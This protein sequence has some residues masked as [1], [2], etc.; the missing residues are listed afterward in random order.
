MRISINGRRV[1]VWQR[2]KGLEK[3]TDFRHPAKGELR[4]RITVAPAKHENLSKRE[5]HFHSV[6]VVQEIVGVRMRSI[7]W[8]G[9][10]RERTGGLL[11]RGGQSQFWQSICLASAVHE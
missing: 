1:R 8:C 11:P 7:L 4:R 2:G 6:K 10:L 3:G 9:Y 5:H